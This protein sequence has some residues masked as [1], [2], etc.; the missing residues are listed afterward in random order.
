MTGMRRSNVVILILFALGCTPAPAADAERPEPAEATEPAH[1]S[2]EPVEPVEP[3]EPTC[4]GQPCAPPRECVQYY[5]IA[6]PS[7]PSFHACE[8]RCERQAD[9][10]TCPEGMRCTTIAD[11]PGDV[12]R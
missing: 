6:G 11:G 10:D 4:E 5:G 9:G 7:G 12:C 3:R 1:T 2:V 8:L